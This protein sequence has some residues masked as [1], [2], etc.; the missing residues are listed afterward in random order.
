MKFML[1]LFTLTRI[2]LEILYVGFHA[3]LHAQYAKYVPVNILYRGSP[4][5][6]AQL[7]D[8]IQLAVSGIDAKMIHAAVVGVIT[9]LNVYYLVVAVMWSIF[10]FKIKFSILLLCSVFLIW[11]NSPVKTCELH[12]SVIFLT[13]YF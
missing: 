6:L 12:L 5:S 8:A 4:D 13:N 3:K 10:C 7:K 1:C 11:I 9:R 2:R